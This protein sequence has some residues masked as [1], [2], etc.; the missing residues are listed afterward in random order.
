MNSYVNSSNQSESSTSNSTNH[1]AVGQ[2]C[3]EDAVTCITTSRLAEISKLCS[4]H[5]ITFDFTSGESNFSDVLTRPAGKVMK[6]G[7]LTGPTELS[8]SDFAIVLPNYW[9]EDGEMV[10]GSSCNVI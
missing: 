7:Y 3:L 10:S 5:P 8:T 2:C 9:E 4:I 6:S 1:R